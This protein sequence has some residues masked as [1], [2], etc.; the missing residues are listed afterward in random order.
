MARPPT[1]VDALSSP[2]AKGLE[3]MIFSIKPDEVVP[4]PPAKAGGAFW[5]DALAP[6]SM[7]IPDIPSTNLPIFLPR[8]SCFP[9]FTLAL[10]ERIPPLE[11]EPTEPESPALALA[12]FERMPPLVAEPTESEVLWAPFERMPPLVA[13]P[14]ESE[15]LWAPFERIPPL[16][17]E[18]TEPKLPFERMPPL[19][20]EPTELTEPELPF[21][22]MPPLVA[23][24]TELTEPELPF[25]RMLPLVA[26][27]T[28]LTEPE[29]V[30]VPPVM[31]EVVAVA[32]IGMVLHSRF[33]RMIVL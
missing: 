19:V 2:L 31:D 23:E 7:F 10:F 24:P 3:F 30:L 21:E 9:P 17:A 20:A 26:E 29:F 27:P 14:T 32:L 11:A 16:V 15:L 12:P 18:L 5:E 6:A 4:A 22:R 33:V 13:E 8:T 1:V 25:E 28:E